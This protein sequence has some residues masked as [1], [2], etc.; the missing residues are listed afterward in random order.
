MKVGF[1]AQGR[2]TDSL[3]DPRFGRCAYFLIVDT[4]GDH[5]EVLENPA[6]GAVG[7]AGIQAAQLVIQ[8]GV[9]AVVTGHVGP[10]AMAA[11]QAAGVRVF[12]SPGGTV[13]ENLELLKKGELPELSGA[14]VPPHAGMGRGMGRGGGRGGRWSL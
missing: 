13:R 1:S 10:N 9:E 6:Q 2:D 11:L 8:R 12:Q 5:W 3:V 7:G 14:T 4:E